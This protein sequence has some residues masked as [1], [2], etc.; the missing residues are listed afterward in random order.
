MHSNTTPLRSEYAANMALCTPAGN[1]AWLKA[2]TCSRRR[3]GW[4]ARLMGL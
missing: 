1:A 3:R 2:S 4:L